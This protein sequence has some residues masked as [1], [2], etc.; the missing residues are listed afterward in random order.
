MERAAARAVRM[1]PGRKVPSS[2]RLPL[3]PAA[4]EAGGLADAV[5]AGNAAGR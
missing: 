4:A 1:H 5:Q 2:E 3:A